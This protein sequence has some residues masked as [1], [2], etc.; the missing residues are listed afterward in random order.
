M[1]AINQKEYLKKYLKIGKSSDGK[2]KK[3]KP[4][5]IARKGLK[6]IDDDADA[7]LSQQIRDDLDANNEDAPQIVA[8][9]DE[10]PPSLRIDEKTKNPLWQPIG[11]EPPLPTNPDFKPGGIKLNMRKERTGSRKLERSPDVKREDYQSNSPKIKQEIDY[12]PPRRQEDQSRNY[13][14]PRRSTNEDESPPRRSRTQDQSPPRRKQK[15]DTARVK[16]EDYS[17]PRRSINEDQSPPRRSRNQDQSPPRRKQKG[18]TARIK[19]EDYSPPRRSMN[20]DQSPPRRKQKEATAKIKQEDYS[21]PR[22]RLIEDQS[23]PRRSRNQDQSPPRRKQKVDYSPPRRSTKGDQSPPR[24]S[25]E[26]TTKRKQNEGDFPGKTNKNQAQPPPKTPRNPDESSQFAKPSEPSSSR[27]KKSRWEEPVTIVVEQKSGLQAAQSFAEDLIMKQ[28]AEEL[29]LDSMTPDQSGV[30]AA[31]ISRKRAKDDAPIDPEKEKRDEEIRQQY[32]RW[33][34][35]LKQVE[36]EAARMSEQAREMQKP[37]ARYA[38]DEDLERYLKEQER[39]GD[40]MLAYIRKKKKKLDV[41]RGVPEKPTYNGDFMPNRF[42][43][44]PGHRWDGVD[45]SNGYEKKW[46]DSINSKKASQEEA[47]QWSQEDM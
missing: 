10:R 26:R 41:Q 4:N 14:P 21:P 8:V 42:G 27:S 2:K 9:I 16:Q 22:R 33:G 31:T 38:D 45:R 13:S 6:I 46:I 11:D 28:K 44:A 23:P 12:S 5:S 30:N 18:A 37:L 32:S 39:D 17:P 35:G 34:K 19:Q 25:K 15:E 7:S 29:L 36:D 24:R 20:E 40:P 1:S 43:I 47:L 3:K